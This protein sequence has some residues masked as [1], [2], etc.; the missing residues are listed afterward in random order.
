MQCAVPYCGSVRHTARNVGRTAWENWTL[1]HCTA[2]Y[3]HCTALHYT[4]LHYTTLHYT[5]LH[6]ITLHCATQ[7]CTTLCSLSSASQ[8][9]TALCYTTLQ[10]NLYRNVLDFTAVVFIYISHVGT[11]R[12]WEQQFQQFP[13]CMVEIQQ[14]Q[15]FQQLQHRT[16]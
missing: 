7:D 1:S 12:K 13:Y 5:A 15:Q 2:L 3:Y 6:Y 16:E 14:F 9:F 11:G 8:Y 4:T 10:T